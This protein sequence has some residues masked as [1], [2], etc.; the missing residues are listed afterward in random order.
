MV[1][2]AP[3]NEGDII[4]SSCFSRSFPVV[5]WEF[6]SEAVQAQLGRLYFSKRP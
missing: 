4:S 5:F 6:F 3:E 2:L 1:Y